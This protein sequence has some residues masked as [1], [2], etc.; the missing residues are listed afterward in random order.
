M[1]VR[2]NKVKIKYFF[3]CVAG[4]FHDDYIKISKEVRQ[5]I[6]IILSGKNFKCE[7]DKNDHECWYV[8]SGKI[9]LTINNSTED[10]E[11]LIK[12][13]KVR[14]IIEVTRMYH[15][16]DFSSLFR[17][18]RKERELIKKDDLIN[19]LLKLTVPNHVK[20]IYSFPFVQIFKEYKSVDFNDFGD[21]SISSFLY[22]VT[23]A[24][25]E[26]LFSL[27]FRE[28]KKTIVR[29]SRPSIIASEMS[30][31]M[32]SEV[33][34]A[35]YDTCL[36]SLR[37][38]DLAEPSDEIFRDMRDY[39]SRVLFDH[40]ETVASA[41][42]TRSVNTL[43]IIMSMGAI[44]AFLAIIYVF[45]YSNVINPFSDTGKSYIGII[46]LFFTIMIFSLFILSK[47]SRL[48]KYE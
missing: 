1:S 25:R 19:K 10:C 31:F 6:D 2:E 32:L 40:E 4:R 47:R 26:S 27:L 7:G 48:K 3:L 45:P 18:A 22:E 21:E 24:R 29:V 33:I 13:F 41:E 20:K 38:N 14:L 34:N 42:L 17:N 35:V 39:I 5:N 16:M 36:H 46:L 11:I 43:S 8:W 9:S 37:K 12:H 30:Y 15:D 23:D 28:P 44:A